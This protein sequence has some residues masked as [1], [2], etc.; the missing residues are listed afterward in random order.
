MTTPRSRQSLLSPAEQRCATWAD[1]VVILGL[2]FTVLQGWIFII[3]VA[4]P[5]LVSVPAGINS[6]RWQATPAKVTVLEP[7]E[8]NRTAG[9]Q[10]R[11]VHYTYVVG[12]QQYESSRYLPGLLTNDHLS[13]CGEKLWNRLRQ[14]VGPDG[15]FLVTAYVN[16]QHPA[17]SALVRGLP[18]SGNTLFGIMSLVVM[19]AAA[20]A[21]T[22]SQKFSRKTRALYEQRQQQGMQ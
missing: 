14:H 1:A 18:L 9:S 6:L 20:Y 8:C 21:W 2:L 12:R 4:L 5:W 3:S 11:G 7:A 16:P 22:V 17:Q 19:I 13:A 10:R 15:T